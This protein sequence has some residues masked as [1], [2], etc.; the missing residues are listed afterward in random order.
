M[1]YA[2]ISGFTSYSSQ[3]RP[4]DVV[5]MLRELFIEFDKSCIQKNVYK[6]YTIGG[7]FDSEIFRNNIIDVLDCYVVLGMTNI[8]NRSIHE[9]ARN[10][11]E[12]G[13][14]MIETIKVVRD[15]VNNSDL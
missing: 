15:R 10:V 11:V 12:M 14:S 3:S 9:E 5:K 4:E 6:V 7:K 13:F 2:D 8:N 1:L